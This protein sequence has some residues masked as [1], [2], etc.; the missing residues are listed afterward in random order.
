VCSS[1]GDR[2]TACKGTGGWRVFVG[3]HVTKCVCRPRAY[4]PGVFHVLPPHLKS[5]MPAV[6]QRNICGISG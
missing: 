3:S 4:A 1:E 2:R 5:E 6:W